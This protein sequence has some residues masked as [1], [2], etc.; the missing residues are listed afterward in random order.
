[1]DL[2]ERDNNL[3][4]LFDRLN[5]L[6]DVEKEFDAMPGGKK[7][8][9]FW[10]D[11]K[12]PEIDSTSIINKTRQKIRRDAMK[13]RKNYFM[14]IS[15][16]IAAS[17][18]L[19]VGAFYFLNQEK[20]SG[21]S[22]NAI[23]QEMTHETL[24]EVTLITSDNQVTL[25]DNA[26]VMYSKDGKVAVNNQEM[27]MKEAA[28]EKDYNQLLVPAGKRARIELSD[29]TILSVNSR[30][31]VIYPRR[32]TGDIRKIYAQGEVFLD[33]AHD[34][35]HPFVVESD[36]FSLRVLGTRFNISNYKEMGET[37]IVLVEG[38]VEVVDT[39]E[40]KAVL[41][42]NDLLNI[43]DGTVK[44]QRK[45][46]VSEYISWMD[47]VILLNGRNLAEITQRLSAYY[48][49]PI[50]CSSAVAGEKIYGKLELKGSLMDVLECI[51]QLL[52]LDL[53][54]KGV[55]I[56]LERQPKME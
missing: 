55:E 38:A 23:A 51:Q 26:Y 1:M 15:T 12:Q 3:S 13:R 41:A 31:K 9:S 27:E 8:K 28:E 7:L 5:S 52:P 54:K 43:E 42:P 45:V 10:M 20:E 37:N 36:D 35:K 39:H 17:V 19:C 53:E 34:K 18:L 4:E 47:G 44:G 32:F 46:D 16:S 48:G 6:Q 50:H 21:I 22:F 14:L 40:N 11:G 2:K 24:D 25:D 30:S 49:T 56:Y 29:G 33:V